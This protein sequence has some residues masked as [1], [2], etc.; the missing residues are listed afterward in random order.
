MA[1]VVGDGF[2]SLCTVHTDG[3]LSGHEFLPG[4]LESDETFAPFAFVPI[5]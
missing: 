2:S 3:S 4:G 5:G 1:K